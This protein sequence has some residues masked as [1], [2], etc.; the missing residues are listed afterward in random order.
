MEWADRRAKD[1]SEIISAVADVARSECQRRGI[2]PNEGSMLVTC[3]AY[4]L[5]LQHTRM[6]AEDEQSTAEALAVT[7]MRARE[8]G[9]MGRAD[10]VCD[11]MVCDGP[12]TVN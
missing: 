8:L 11:D 9:G 4:A 10:M 1:Y 2:G 3:A 7:L 5:V 6:S 12:V